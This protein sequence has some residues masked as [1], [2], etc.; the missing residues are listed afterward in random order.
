MSVFSVV[1]SSF[2]TKSALPYATG[3]LIV[4]CVRSRSGAGARSS[5]SDIINRNL[6]YCSK[7]R[8]LLRR[9]CKSELLFATVNEL[10]KQGELIAAAHVAT[11]PPLLRSACACASHCVCVS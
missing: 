8:G 3:C 10:I 2:L 6:L 7:P 11:I 4:C 5:A 1:C 9:M